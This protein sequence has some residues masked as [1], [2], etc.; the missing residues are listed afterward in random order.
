MSE[1]RS[2]LPLLAAGACAVA[3][4]A[5]TLTH[6]GGPVLTA[7]VGVPLVLALPG[8][9]LT[10]ALLPVRALALPER[11]ALA[12][13]SSLAVAAVSGLVLQSLSLKLGAANWSLFLALTTLAG[14][15][16]ALIRR[17]IGQT[18]IAS[19]SVL[20]VSS[21]TRRVGTGQMALM[22]L[23]TAITL[24]AIALATDGA[25]NPPAPGFT[26][27][28]LQSPAPDARSV[29]VGMQSN[30]HQSARYRIEMA[31]D[32]RPTT[33][34]SG[35]TLRPGERWGAAV[36]L[37]DVPPQGDR[38]QVFVYREDA[39]GVY[40]HVELWRRQHVQ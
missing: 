29:L 2:S 30:E 27:V 3:A 26:Q 10:A 15:L 5:L 38:V 11:I 22:I 1:T 39:S 6:V 17:R 36:D 32:G 35:I 14:L 12:I 9:A 33:Q 40:R 31:V 4:V 18:S 37:P 34:W 7:A 25:L 20:A 21:R 19:E 23:A 24:A 8:Y 28:W 13:G 16:I